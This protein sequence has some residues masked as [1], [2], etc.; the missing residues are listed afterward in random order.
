[1]WI[2]TSKWVLCMPFKIIFLMLK[3]VVIWTSERHAE[4]PFAG[5]I[6]NTYSFIT[7]I[8][9]S[10]CKSLKYLKY[11]LKILSTPETFLVVLISFWQLQ[12]IHKPAFIPTHTPTHPTTQSKSKELVW[13]YGNIHRQSF[14]MLALLRR[15]SLNIGISAVKETDYS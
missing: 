13:K 3:Q 14:F 7:L 5:Q 9:T 1:M 10:I 6:Q 2:S 8:F 15:A 12:T 4:H 11:F